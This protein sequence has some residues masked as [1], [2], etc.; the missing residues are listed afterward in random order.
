MSESKMIIRYLGYRSQPDG[1]RQFDFT[2]AQGTEFPVEITIHALPAFFV[3]PDRIAIQ[4]ATS[5]CYETLRVR[6][7]A[8]GDRPPRQFD[9]TSADVARHRKAGKSREVRR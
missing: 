3:G 8:S 2:V 6:I 5:I 7:H 9:L 4:E 1:G